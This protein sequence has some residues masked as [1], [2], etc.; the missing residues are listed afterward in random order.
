MNIERNL[1][2]EPTMMALQEVHVEICDE[3]L[4]WLPSRSFMF[5]KASVVW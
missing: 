3:F 5:R 2:Q 1:V 4:Y